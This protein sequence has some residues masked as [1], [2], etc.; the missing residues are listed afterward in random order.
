MHTIELILS[1]IKD[2]GPLPT[3]AILV[4]ADVTGL[5]TNVPINDGLDA[6]YE[7]C[8]KIKVFLMDI[9]QE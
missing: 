6:M 3:N 2:E 8:E 1:K 7:A 9:L 4:T 5:Y